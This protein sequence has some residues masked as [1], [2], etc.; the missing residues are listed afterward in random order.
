V[1][2]YIE[3]S[4]KRANSV[5]VHTFEAPRPGFISMDVI[6]KLLVTT[7]ATA[8]TTTT[9]T[10]TTTTTT[11]CLGLKCYHHTFAGTL[12]KNLD[13][14]LLHSSMQTSATDYTFYV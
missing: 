5:I 7:T 3:I 2:C 9:I 13:L 8:T 12:Y 14:K 4:V 1:N 11:T 10:T 6:R